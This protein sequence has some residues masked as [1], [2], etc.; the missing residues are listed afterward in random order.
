MDYKNGTDIFPEE[1]IREIQKYISGGLVYPMATI[2]NTPI[3]L[4]ESDCHQIKDLVTSAFLQVGD[5]G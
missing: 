2:R 5:N 4:C 3:T 1:L